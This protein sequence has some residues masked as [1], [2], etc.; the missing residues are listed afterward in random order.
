M[1]YSFIS[2]QK[3]GYLHV[4]VGGPNDAATVRRYLMDLLAAS[5][6]TGCPN[7]LVEEN[8]E[9][10]RLGMGEIFEIVTK[11][12]GAAKHEVHRIAYVDVNPEHNLKSMKFA[13]TVATNRGLTVSVFPSVEEAERWMQGQL[14]GAASPPGRRLPDLNG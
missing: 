10:S 12:S 1:N 11:A 2:E 13:E 5:V 9:G 7:V 6:A 4:R 14:R 3:D 8:L